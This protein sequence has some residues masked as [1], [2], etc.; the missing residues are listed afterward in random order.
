MAAQALQGV[1]PTAGPHSSGCPQLGSRILN[2]SQ[3]LV[4]GFGLFETVL[5][6][7]QADLKTHRDLTTSVLPGLGL[8]V[9]LPRP[10]SG[11]LLNIHKLL[12]LLGG[13]GIPSLPCPGGELQGEWV[14]KGWGAGQAVQHQD[15]FL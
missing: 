14:K 1:S 12:G 4:F 2:E 13:E 7:D 5:V 6:C 15:L 3:A 9:A 8:K 10:A 11:F